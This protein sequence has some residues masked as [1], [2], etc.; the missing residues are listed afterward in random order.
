[1]LRDHGRVVTGDNAE[2][3]RDGMVTDWWQ[4]R[5]NGEPALMLAR[6]NVDVDDLNRRARHLMADA[7]QLSGEP[8]VIADRPF[9]VGDEIVCL[10]NDTRLDV[11]NGTTAT[12]IRIDH[13]RR[14]VTIATAGGARS[15]D[16]VY[17]DAGHV[18]HG[19]AVTVHKAQGRTTDHS[20][21]LGTDDLTRESGYVGL[22][23]G[24][25]TNRMYVL[26]PGH[27]L[28][29]DELEHHGRLGSVNDPSDAV[30][31]ALHRSSTKH[32]AADHTQTT[33]AMT[34]ELDDGVDIGW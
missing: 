12:I 13:E 16:A 26:D 29:D 1:M 22:S 6:R 32:L 34:G 30:L 5:Q 20:L 28:D 10:R 18:R 3:V 21:L 11:V 9:Q 7:G 17:V 15:L 23:R 27:G 19:Y 24:R 25:L 14:R 2:T 4:H 31:H 8:L 33:A